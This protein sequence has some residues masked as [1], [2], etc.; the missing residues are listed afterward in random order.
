MSKDDFNIKLYMAKRYMEIL[1]KYHKWSGVSYVVWVDFPE[2]VDMT[3][4]GELYENIERLELHATNRILIQVD[5]KCVGK[6][7]VELS[8]ESDFT[9]NYLYEMFHTIG[10]DDF[11][12]VGY[13][14]K[15]K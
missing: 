10:V 8:I 6:K 9:S 12:Y 11:R 15:L 14:N 2:C 1:S 3:I 7:A 4:C 5:V 13:D